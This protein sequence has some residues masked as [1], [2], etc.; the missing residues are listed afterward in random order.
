[1][2]RTTELVT[3]ERVTCDDCGTGPLHT[4]WTDY[5]E[6]GRPLLDLCST[7]FAKRQPDERPSYLPGRMQQ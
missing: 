4:F 5:A 3:V 1:M 2:S 7:C 6:D